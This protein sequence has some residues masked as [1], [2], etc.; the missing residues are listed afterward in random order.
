M[1][2][3]KKLVYALKDVIFVF[4]KAKSPRL[5]MT[6]LVKN[7][8]E[9]L[10]KNLI[11][12]KKM[13]VDAFIITDNNSSDS[14]PDIIEKY[15]EKGWIIDVINET[16]TNYEQKEW[17]DRM[18]WRA[19]TIFNAD[20]II[21]ADADEFWYTPL[22]N[23][24]NEMNNTRCNVLNCELRSMYP[25]EEKPFWQWSKAV[26]TV[27]NPNEYELSLYSL[28]ER[29]NKKVA[30]RANGYMQI[31]MGN[32]KV[33]M[34]PQCSCDSTIRIYHYNVR[35]RQRFL[36]KMINGGKQLEQH[37]RRHGG[38]HWRYFYRL[39]KEGL[40]NEE[41]DKVIG[42]KFYDKLYEDGYIYEDTAIVDFFKTHLPK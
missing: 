25:D 21:N 18:I 34:F 40:L 2:F 22:G 20:W 30:H 32:H 37:K 17:V 5:I 12:H 19:K 31:S 16:A 42:T 6:L 27:M 1:N 26:K 29:Q 7:E 24:K 14:T 36:D 28:F 8:E 41:Y 3:L 11:F 39:Y 13:G 33:K 15:Q 23:L 35:S 10:E 38:R 9:L 4:R